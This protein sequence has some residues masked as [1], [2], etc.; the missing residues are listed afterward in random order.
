MSARRPTPKVQRLTA[1]AFLLGAVVGGVLAGALGGVFGAGLALGALSVG[2]TRLPAPARGALVVLL[3]VGG[4]GALWVGAGF[5]YATLGLI[6]G[7][8]LAQ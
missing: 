8:R 2:R 3:L 1:A 5:V 6:E 4:F 7:A